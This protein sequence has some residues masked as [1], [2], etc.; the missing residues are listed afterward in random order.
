MIVVMITQLAVQV[1]AGEHGY[2]M[3]PAMIMVVIM[4]LAVKVAAEHGYIIT[5]AMIMVVIMRL[6]VK[7]ATE[8]KSTASA[9][10]IYSCQ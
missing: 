3:A 6:A 10:P 5:P 7:V 4:R 2:I 1:A 8:Q 9:D